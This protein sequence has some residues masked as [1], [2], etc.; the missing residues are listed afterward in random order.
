MFFISINIVVLLVTSN[1]S[2]HFM[3]DIEHM[4]TMKRY[5]Y[6]LYEPND[7]LTIIYTS[8]STG[9]PKGAI[10]NE[11][12]FRSNFPAIQIVSSAENVVFSYRP[13][14]WMSDREAVITGVIRGG[15]I[16]F[17]TGDHSRLMEEISLVRPTFLGATPLIWNQIYRDFKAAY[18]LNTAHLPPELHATEKQ[19]LLQKFSKLI[20]RRCQNISIGGAMVSPALL[21]FLNLCFKHCTIFESY[22]ISEC[23]SVTLNN[24]LERDNEYSLESVP[25]LG[26]SVD[27]LPN[28]RGELLIKTRHLFS[29]YINN[30]EETAAAFTKDGFFRTGDIVEVHKNEITN[31]T[32]FYVIDRKKNFFKLSQGQFVSPEYLQTIYLQSPFVDQIY[33]HGDLTSGTVKAVIVPNQD[34]AEKYFQKNSQQSISLNWNDPSTEYLDLIRQDLRR[35]ANQEQLRSHEFPQE[36]IIDCQRFT[37]ENGLL[38][39]SMKLCRPKLAQYYAKR[40]QTTDSVDS[41]LERIINSIH[42]QNQIPSSVDIN[43]LSLLNT[44]ND[45]LSATRLSRMI[46]NDLGI[47]IPL[48]MLFDP[49]MNIS[50]LKE[51]IKNPPMVAQYLLTLQTRLSVDARLDPSIKIIDHRSTNYQHNLKAVTHV[52]LTGVTGFIGCFLLA[53][54]ISFYPPQT[55][56]VC[57]VRSKS[58]ADGMKYI[59]QAMN[60]YRLWNTDYEQRIIPL[61]GDLSLIYFGL[62]AGV[63]SDLAQTIEVIFHCAAQVNSILPYHRLYPSNVFGTQ[64]IIRLATSNVSFAIPIHYLSSM[65]VLE[66][67]S[68]DGEISVDR[69][70]HESLTSGYAQSKWVAEKLIQQLNDAGHPVMIYRLGRIGPHQENGACNPVDLYTLL[71]IVIIRL[72]SY[73]KKIQ[74]DCRLLLFPIDLTTKLLVYLSQNVSNSL[75]N[76]IYHVIDQKMDF[77]IRAIVDALKQRGI[78]LEAVEMDRW[79]QKVDE[80]CRKNAQFES[81]KDFLISAEFDDKW[82]HGSN[83]KFARVLEKIGTTSNKTEILSHWIEFV[84]FSNLVQ[85]E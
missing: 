58:V 18:A 63:F 34:Y 50:R 83:T 5:D 25:E 37:P 6:M 13:L 51:M 31:Q 1:I 69:I 60:F 46:E 65:S 72:K 75:G 39:S 55:K 61:P 30:P 17:F 53:E 16:A 15:R 70:S 10:L 57:L 79:K 84:L 56:F 28:P 78:D 8:G 54:L 76:H 35:L 52:F 49:D 48:S 21:S 67:S 19:R 29:G 47:A 22:G 38:T 20:P 71:L 12:V 42:S 81:V 40:F 68:I 82:K 2:I 33:I 62:D 27:D 14:A 26:Y 85:N 24:V 45:S 44:N 73:P 43:N 74:N 23:G 4:G 66:G 59:K 80:F 3:S 64:E 41:V 32:T 7:D 77:E 11:S 36:I 9:S